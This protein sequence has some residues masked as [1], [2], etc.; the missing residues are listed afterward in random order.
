MKTFHQ[1]SKI[2]I[3]KNLQK[4]YDKILKLVSCSPKS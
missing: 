3:V 2:T 1:E 4:A